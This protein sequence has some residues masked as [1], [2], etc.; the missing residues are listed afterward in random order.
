[1]VES[2][3]RDAKPDCVVI[4]PWNF[5]EEVTRQLENIKRGGGRFVTAVPK[6]EAG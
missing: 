1:V 2:G 6:L 4:L 3:L 5:K